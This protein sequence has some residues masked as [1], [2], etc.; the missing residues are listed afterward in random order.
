MPDDENQNE[1]AALRARVAALEGEAAARPAPRHRGRSFL[2]AV[3]IV[4]GCLL[5]PLGIV[6]AWTSD[7][8][9]DTDRYVSTVA[10][11]ASDADVQAAV[12]N[13]VTGAVMEHIDLEDLLEGV[14]PDQRPL[15]AKALGKLGGSLESAVASFVHDKAQDV[16]ASDAFETVW[17][18]ANRAIH[19]SV[20]R[21]L[22]GSGDGAVQINN[23]TVT[24]DLAPVI[25]RVKERL[26]D[27]GLTVAG[28]IPEIHTDFTVVKSDDI[29]KVKTG[30]RL[31]QVMGLW[32]PVLAV[33]LVVAG[34]LLSTH[35]RR[36]VIAS[37]IGVAA[38]ALV[39]GIALT[40]FR[41]VYLNA[42]PDT[43]SQAAA[44]SVY[45][46]LIH[47]LRTTVRMVVTLGLV[48][49]LGA[50]LTGPSRP[51]VVVR[52]MWNSGIDATR[53][54]ADRAGL[55]TGPVGPFVR[56]YRT[57]ITWILVILAV[58]VYVLWNHPT[59][60]VVV[61]LALALLFAFAVVRFLG[62]EPADAD[63]E[64][65]LRA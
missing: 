2:A 14:A 41:T 38:A 60:W 17:T 10:P 35:R 25:D 1:L 62:A 56:R 42:L 61:G 46:A 3:L 34:V 47:F 44:G 23:D 52:R 48:V 15:L 58:V 26:V 13:R 20:V 18:D 33:L 6:A 43:V 27:S 45:D 54:A 53:G 36:T 55:R 51:A 7:I 16:V 49:A 32:L 9:G 5:V 39:L 19:T 30:F 40:V 8:V 22:T 11:L 37:A 65:P 31:L 57:W 64:A 24:V 21:A 50:W 12:A 4:I 29:G 28:K 59:G 63:G